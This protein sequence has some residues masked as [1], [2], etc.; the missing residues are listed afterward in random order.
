MKKY[1]VEFNGTEILLSLFKKYNTERWV[2]SSKDIK[3]KSNNFFEGGKFKDNHIRKGN[4]EFGLLCGILFDSRIDTIYFVSDVK[5]KYLS[6][7]L[8][9]H[10]ENHYFYIRNGFNLDSLHKKI[11]LTGNKVTIRLDYWTDLFSLVLS[12]EEKLFIEEFLQKCEEKAESLVKDNLAKIRKNKNELLAKQKSIFSSFDKDGD[13][14]VDLIENDFHKLFAKNQNIILTIDK[15]YIHQFVKISNFI[16]Q[17]RQN[18]QNIFTSI[19]NT[20]SKKEL[21]ERTGLLSNQIHT[22]ELLVFHSINMIGALIEN[23]L[24]TFYE[25]YEAFDKLG[26]Y[27]SNWENEVSEKLLNIGNKLNDLMYSI[28]NMEQSI[29]NELRYLN[30]TTQESFKDLNRS[31]TSHLKDIDSSIRVNNLWTVIQSYQLYKINKN[32]KGLKS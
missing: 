25:I 10:Y 21:D 2:L 4:F 24:I 31:L 28:Q 26:I 17:K 14:E 16:K 15:T 13:G 12:N 18:I 29:V 30:Y 27:N 6:S 8:D 9:P 23:D 11:K 7:W 3:E 32:T 19:K 1:T 5:C 22:Y 20:N